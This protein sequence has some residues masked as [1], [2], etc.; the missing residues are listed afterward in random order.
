MAR[1]YILSDELA[2]IYLQKGCQGHFQS[3][4]LSVVEFTDIFENR[5]FNI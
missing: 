2:M 1:A 4:H 5:Y 3:R